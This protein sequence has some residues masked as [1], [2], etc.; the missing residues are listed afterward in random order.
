VQK[1]AKSQWQ[2]FCDRVSRGLEGARAE[3]EI[4]SKDLGD[5]VMAKWLP[6]L[7]LTYDSKNDLIEVALEGV[8]HLIHNPRAVW[9]Y[10]SGAELIGF[11]VFDGR[12]MQHVIKL[13]EPLRLPPAGSIAQAR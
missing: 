8:D 11:E 5:E 9:V 4:T 10:M 1:I 2:E 7:G 12:G 13:R 6:L 3:I